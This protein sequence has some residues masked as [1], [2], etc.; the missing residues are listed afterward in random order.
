MNRAPS[1][2]NALFAGAEEFLCLICLRI[3]VRE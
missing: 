1:G 2:R 3:I